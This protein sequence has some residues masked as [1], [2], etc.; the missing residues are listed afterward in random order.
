MASPQSREQ[1]VHNK[2][3]NEILNW[4]IYQITYGNMLGFSDTG[5]LKSHKTK[6]CANAHWMTVV[7]IIFIFFTSVENAAADIK[8]RYQC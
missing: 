5:R 1:W 6:N 8:C 3:L 4:I 7:F 2:P